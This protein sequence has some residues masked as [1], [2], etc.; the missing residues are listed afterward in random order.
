M[1]ITNA[2]NGRRHLDSLLS[3]ADVEGL[4]TVARSVRKVPGYSTD[5]GALPQLHSELAQHKI[6]YSLT[7]LRRGAPQRLS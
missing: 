5:I 4:N 6:G 1:H 2:V 3:A 7:E